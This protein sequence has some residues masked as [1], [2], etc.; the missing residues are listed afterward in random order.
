M[1]LGDKSGSFPQVG[2]SIPAPVTFVGKRY[3]FPWCGAG[4]PIETHV[5]SIVVDGSALLGDGVPV[6][7]GPDSDHK[8]GGR[9][10]ES[11]GETP[12]DGQTVRTDWFRNAGVP[13][14]I[15]FNRL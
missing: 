4:F 8:F 14:L 5:V 10:L 1:C 12:G 13:Y 9:L 2:A 15:C 6:A 11:F 3:P 7:A